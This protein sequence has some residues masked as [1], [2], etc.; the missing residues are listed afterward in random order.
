MD[1]NRP[2]TSNATLD[3]GDRPQLAA[4]GGKIASVGLGIGGA[5]A[6]LVLL[7]VLYVA[8]TGQR[9]FTS[10]LAIA[11]YY[12]LPALLAIVLFAS[13][14]K[15]NGLQKLRLLIS[16]IIVLGSLYAA[17]LFLT[18]VKQD[19]RPEPAMLS[20]AKAR[21]KEAYAAELTR[22]FGN[23][24]DIRGPSEVIDDLKRDGTDVIPIV[25]PSNHLF[26]RQSDGTVRSA[27]SIDGREVMPLSSV[28]RIRTLVCNED[29]RWIDF[30]TDEHGFNN[31]DQVWQ[32]DRLDV[33]ALGDSFAH[34]YCV[35]RDRN[36]VDLIRRQRPATLNLGMAGDGPLLMLATLDEY[37][38]R[39][40]PRNVLWFYFEGNDLTDLQEER[41]STLLNRYLTGPF[42]QPDL[43]RRADIDRALR[44]ELPRLEA[45]EREA[46]A[47]RTRNTVRGLVTSVAKLSSIRQR[48]G[49][50]GET[51]VN[52]IAIGEDLRTTNM[53]VFRASLIQAKARTAGWGGRLYFVYLPEWAR[54]TSYE[55][56]GKGRRDEVLQLVRDLGIP[57]IDLDPPIRATGDPLSLFPF[58]AQ[59]H[60]S[61]AGHRMVADE[62]LRALQ[63]SA[64]GSP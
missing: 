45:A 64:D 39:L 35:P 48:L 24:I 52:Q 32:L 33:A 38:P 63:K 21:N 41:K 11:V 16:C 43:T 58:R 37:L 5:L 14:L 27:I 19:E 2:N 40:R 30:K 26:I 51:D 50:I 49:I 44:D 10:A 53:D 54:Y 12:G 55:S 62:V 9:Q 3:R 36:F 29:G 42:T 18:F 6:L 46:A 23:A 57:I 25:T 34:G 15:L 17:E 28:S 22:K 60:Y 61:E 13:A 47:N 1:E 31:D 59:S 56:W 8:L 7:R 20:V 4:L